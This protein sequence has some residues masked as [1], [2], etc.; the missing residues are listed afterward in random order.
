MTSRV[1]ENA[2]AMRDALYEMLKN[3]AEQIGLLVIV[4]GCIGG[5][6]QI[7]KSSETK[8]MSSFS[9]TFLV[10]GIACE[11]MLMGQGYI[12]GTSTTLFIRAV[13]TAYTAYLL[14][15]YTRSHAPRPGPG[16]RVG[17]Q[18]ARDADPRLSKG[19][20]QLAHPGSLAETATAHSAAGNV[21]SATLTA[22][23]ASLTMGNAID[24]YDWTTGTMEAKNMQA[25]SPAAR[26]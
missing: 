5:V 24:I 9:P 2:T 14:Y 13:T 22:K 11:V 26:P 23:P 16:A 25:P 6:A 4:V 18:P 1:A 15:L 3:P 20:S 21:H 10:C 8:D 19:P 17:S 7:V 12:Q